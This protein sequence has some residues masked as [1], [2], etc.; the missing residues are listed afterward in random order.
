M[1]EMGNMCKQMKISSENDNVDTICKQKL[2][3]IIEKEKENELNETIE[4]I[5][6]NE[7][8]P[9]EINKKMRQRRMTYSEN[10]VN[11]MKSS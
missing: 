4:K 11:N 8:Q 2:Y 5:Q 7:K 9:T 1:S 3:T 10:Q 6:K